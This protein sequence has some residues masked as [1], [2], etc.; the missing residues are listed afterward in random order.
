[1]TNNTPDYEN[2]LYFEQNSSKDFVKDLKV[3][4]NSESLDKE[5]QDLMIEMI[6]NN[7]KK[8]YLPLKNNLSQIDLGN[9]IHYLSNS[10]ALDSHSIKYNVSKNKEDKK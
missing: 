10:I 3:I 8:V 5:K 2:N 7:G 4:N 1:M 6:C 9:F